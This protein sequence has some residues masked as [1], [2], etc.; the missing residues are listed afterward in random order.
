MVV[1]AR[2]TDDVTFNLQLMRDELQNLGMQHYGY[3]WE[4]VS[5]IAIRWTQ[6]G[7][8]MQDTLEQTRVGLLALNV[9]EMDVQMASQG[10][11]A[12]MSQWGFTAKELET[13]VD[14]LN[15]TLIILP[16]P[17]EILLMHL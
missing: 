9:A 2:T 8:D 3:T 7:Y 13:V 16:L 5:D 15:I 17:R 10:M 4:T 11:I 6:A 1:I 12:I 14:K